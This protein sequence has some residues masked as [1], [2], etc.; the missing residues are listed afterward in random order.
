MAALKGKPIFN[1]G[2]FPIDGM[3]HIDEWL[4]PEGRPIYIRKS[5]IWIGL[6][7]DAR[8]DLYGQ[9]LRKSDGDVIN[10]FCWDRYAN[11]N[12]PHQVMSDFHDGDFMEL[13]T[14][15][16]IMLYYYAQAVPGNFNAHMAAWVWYWC[17]G[18]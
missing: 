4:N 16:S 9:L 11:P 6:D 2:A 1:T 10:A 13:G 7:L 15:D 18:G 12:G 3:Q 8:A 17:G 14:N 5:L